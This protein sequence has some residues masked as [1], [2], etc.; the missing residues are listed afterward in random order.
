MST[1]ALAQV[2][3]RRP[4]R[5]QLVA[6]VVLVVLSLAPRSVA[7]QGVVLGAIQ[8]S[9]TDQS[10]LVLPGVTLRLTSPALQVP[11]VVIVSD[12]E[13]RYRFPELRV[14][15]YKIQASLEGFQTLVR[16]NID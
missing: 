8:G 5:R 6:M 3:T 9:I 7:A 2:V 1:S 16:E 13:G 14:G 12:A 10:S 11:E 15:R 4:N